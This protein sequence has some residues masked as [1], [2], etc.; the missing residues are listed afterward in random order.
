MELFYLPAQFFVWE[1]QRAYAVAGI[2]FGLALYTAVR[3]GRPFLIG[4][5]APCWLIFGWLEHLSRLERSDIRVDLLVTWPAVCIVSGV[6]LCQWIR[7][8]GRPV[9]GKGKIPSPGQGEGR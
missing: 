8:W 7:G 6:C 5:P 9:E 2:F 3:G 4:L 1:P